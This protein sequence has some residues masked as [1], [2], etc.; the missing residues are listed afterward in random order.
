VSGSSWT[1]V[2]SKYKSSSFWKNSTA[3]SD[4]KNFGSVGVGRTE[5]CSGCSDHI[6]RSFFRM[7]ISKVKGRNI[8]DAKFRIEQRHAWTCSP[9]S[10]AKLWLTGA[11]SA[12]TTWNNQP[13][14][15]GSYTATTAA[16]RKVGAVHGC[17]GPGGDEFSVTSMVAHSSASTTMTVGLKAIDEGNKNQWKRFNHSSPK[18]AITY[19]TKPGTPGERKSDGK[20]CATGASRPYVLTGTP[21]LAA[22]QTDPD[23]S[24]QNLTTYFYWWPSGGSANET[25]KVSQASG[26]P[27]PVSKAI[28]SGRIA[29]N[30]TYLWKSR[31][32]D[33]TDY[34]AWSGT[35]EFTADLTPPAPPTS[36]A[37][38][39]Y[40]ADEPTVPGHG[41]VGLGAKFIIGAPANRPSDI[42][43]YAYSLDSGVQPSAAPTVAAK[44]DFSGEIPDLIPRKDGVNTLQVWSKERSGR[45][46]ATPFTYKFKVKSGSGPAAS[47]DFDEVGGD[48]ADGTDHGNT[49]ALAG[50]AT[51]AAGRSGV[52]QALSLNGTT[53][54][55]SQAGAV[56]FPHPDTEAT[57]NVAT[58]TSFTVAAWAKLAAT[59]GTAQ[60]TV[61]AANG[62]QSS[63]YTL[64]YSG[65]DNK[66]R[67][68]M[69]GSDGANATQYQILSNAAPTA[70]KWTHIAGTFDVSTKKLTLH[71]NGVAQ[72]AT[73]TLT[74]GF[75]A[76]V[77]VTIG[78]RK[79]NGAADGYFSGEIDDVAVYPFV[80]PAA[81]I[82]LLPAPLPPALSFPDSTPP[83]IGQTSTVRMS[84]GGDINVTSYKYSSPTASLDKTATPAV[85]GGAAEGPITPT[86][87]GTT[88]VYARAVGANGA[89]SQVG[90]ASVQVTGGGTLSG[91]VLDDVDFLPV[92]GAT[93]TLNP[94]RRA[95]T[96]AKDGTYTF[97]DV[98]NGQV[99]VTATVGGRCGKRF[100][101]TFT[102]EGDAWQDLVVTDP[103]DD[104]GYTCDEVTGTFA[105]G[106]TAL[107]LTGDDALAPVDLPFTFPFY[108]Q[109]YRSA[110]VDTNGLISFTDPGL[111]HP[112]DGKSLPGTAMP[113][114]LIAP[115]WDDL[116]VDSSSSVNTTS[117]ASSFVV[118]WRNALR[119][120]TTTDRLSFN[121]IITPDGKV[122][123]SY[124]GLDNDN[125]R[126]AE[127]VIGIE[128]P[129]GADGLTYAASEAALTTGKTVA[130]ATPTGM[131]VPATYSLSG[132]VLSMTGT[133]VSGA[134]VTLDPVGLTATTASDGTYRFDGL[135]PDTYTVQSAQNQ[136]C[137][138]VAQVIVDLT[139]D[140][141]RNLQRALDYG[142]MGYA[143]AQVTGTFTA[144]NN[145]VAALTG[146][147]ATTVIAFP[148][149]VPFHGQSYSSATVS[150]NGFLTFGTALGANT[151]ANPTIPTLAAP[152]AV[153]APFW[154][155]LEIDSSASVRTD[156]IGTAPNRAVRIGSPSRPCSLR[157]LVTSPSTTAR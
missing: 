5:D 68:A 127:A 37:S 13:T 94:G 138:Q 11:I 123:F 81:D 116:V 50:G 98:P 64:G 147:E 140:S 115:F 27:S 105:I 16:N 63:A 39:S 19:N 55:A 70:G 132:K 17:A 76:S 4:G 1:S 151:Y 130:F 15:Y 91:M 67:F 111:S 124:S 110:W 66:W 35:C 131:D 20:A 97:T 126:G 87:P 74:G 101:T 83:A 62:S 47:W 58:T 136:K 117:T 56:H 150:T 51:R 109:S 65:A 118:E 102:L 78:R 139:A 84:A 44:S 156:T 82:A 25:N 106:A 3:L 155:D 52:G 145:V 46:S 152:N 43:A 29:D 141:V 148:F 85:A 72:T 33:G 54:Y 90:V 112:G 53:A 144:A 31:T 142:G 113:D 128:S 71:V 28:P 9:K 8:L 59:G 75:N 89:L 21:I 86:A 60:R 88:T 79:L 41:G 119:K 36:V 34:S 24:Q 146:D 154:D 137:P 7:D 30:T 26:N 14:W 61:I 73:A 6:I 143:C 93:V 12:K 92:A 45:F 80:V 99:T 96:T 18:L 77:D 38:T 108:G 114:G 23:A 153:V 48:A 157:R 135:T 149:A 104:L 107:A 40:P 2:W 22:K 57:T 10:N 95:T 129:D 121:A 134:K 69:A 103:T 32:W 42:V 100:T 125:E 120:G 49:Q 122:T 133:A